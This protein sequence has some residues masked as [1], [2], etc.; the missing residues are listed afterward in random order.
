MA[1]FP[2]LAGRLAG[3][4]RVSHNEH[5][6]RARDAAI[7]VAD[8]H[9]V[10]AAIVPENIAQRELGR[11][12]PG[13]LAAVGQAHPAFEPLVVQR[14][15]ARCRHAK[16]DTL[17]GFP[18][19][20]LRL[21]GDAGRCRWRRRA[22]L[23]RIGRRAGSVDRPHHVIIRRLP[24]QRRVAPASAAE[25]HH[26]HVHIRTPIHRRAPHH[27]VHGIRRVVAPAQVN[28]QTAPRGGRQPARRRRRH[29]RRNEDQL[30]PIRQSYTPRLRYGIGDADVAR[31]ARRKIECPQ[32]APIAVVGLLVGINRRR[33]PVICNLKRHPRRRLRPVGMPLVHRVIPRHHDVGR[34]FH[35]VGPRPL[36]Q[37]QVIRPERIRVRPAPAPLKPWRRVAQHVERPH[38]RRRPRHARNGVVQHKVIDHPSHPA[39][40]PPA[41]I[42]PLLRIVQIGPEEVCPA[43]PPHRR[44]VRI[45]RQ[46]INELLHILVRGRRR[47]RRPIHVLD[48]HQR[49]DRVG[50]IHR[51][52]VDVRGR[53]VAPE[54]LVI[55][56]VHIRPVDRRARRFGGRKMI[57][58][59]HHRIAPIPE[60]LVREGG[61]HPHNRKRRVR[62]KLVR[63]VRAHRRAELPRQRRTVGPDPRLGALPLRF[64]VPDEPIRP[65]RKHVIRD[66][67]L[68]RNVRSVRTVIPKDPQPVGMGRVNQAARELRAAVTP[69]E[70]LVARGRL[71]N[72]IPRSLALQILHQAVLIRHARHIAPKLV[73]GAAH[74]VEPFAFAQ[75]RRVNA[76]IANLGGGRQGAKL[77][78]KANQHGSEQPPRRGAHTCG[79][80]P[81]PC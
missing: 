65:L 50:P 35:V 9:A 74:V 1:R 13:D 54:V 77:E 6:H 56:P 24:C 60:F 2:L 37:R 14:Q 44:T 73:G 79:V 66:R 47:I 41:D 71:H 12:R 21:G 81:P 48:W 31:S 53:Q 10:G 43:I 20:A 75:V 69:V 70:Q 28:S 59:R 76:A 68:R 18:V 40:R 46:I 72:H 49:L 67:N 78:A 80:P 52:P 8:H 32:H 61:V 36:Y 63:P 55:R 30:D 25:R 23:V 51:Q 16:G 42:R 26:R 11:G 27:V 58:L 62:Q 29:R 7:R 57:D 38:P 64:R 15:G 17:A 4:E 19:L 22:R 5:R 3:D 45:R 34:E 33:T 39:E